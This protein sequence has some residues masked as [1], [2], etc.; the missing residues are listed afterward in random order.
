MTNSENIAL[1]A[2]QEILDPSRDVF[3]YELLYRNGDA[4]RCHLTDPNSEAANKATSFV[5]SHLFAQLG[6]QMILGNKKAF[7]NF[8][9][10]NILDGLPGYLPKEK[11]VIEVLENVVIDQEL[12][13]AVKKY[14]RKGYQIALDDFV[15]EEK[16]RPLIDMADY[17]K[18]DVFDLP[19]NEVERQVELLRDFN[20]HLLAEKV[21]TKE[22]YKACKALGFKYFQ[23]YYFNKPDLVEGKKI[24]ENKSYLLHL[25]AELNDP[26]IEFSRIE[27]LIL[28][29]PKLSYRL[30]LLVNSAALY[31]REKIDNLYFA[32]Q[33]LGLV[34]IRNWVSLLLLSGL[35]DVSQSIID[36]TL[37]RAKMGQNLAR[38]VDDV[39]ERQAFTVGMLSTID[40]IIG[41][42]MDELLENIPLTDD[43]KDALINRKGRLGHLLNQ[44]EYYEKGL[45]E[46]IDF[47]PLSY[48]DFVECYVA[49]L[50]YYNSV[51][52]I[53]SVNH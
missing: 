2:R 35:D 22:Q 10:Q 43:I 23:G 40:S 11:V 38:R 42:P 18:V 28:Q 46:M 31:E 17:I 48:D 49:G 20:G 29:T 37:I 25:M 34:K 32:I 4:F 6:Y 13:D 19:L 27:E 26:N 51:R 53:F 41:Q 45:F 9:R 39:D 14:S 3:A 44:V 5:I 30:L 8:T 16:A 52:W 24:S 21:E 15:Y 7:I 47:P 50:E 1:F 36:R 12:I 33:K